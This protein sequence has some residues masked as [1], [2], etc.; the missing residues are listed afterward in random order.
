[1][2]NVSIISMGNITENKIPA[3]IGLPKRVSFPET[4][5]IREGPR[6][7][8][9]SP[10][11]ASIPNT[12]VEPFMLSDA[13]ESVPGHIIPT[14]KPHKPHP[15]S[16]ITGDGES[17]AIRYE[18]AHNTEHIIIHVFNGSLSAYI[19]YSTLEIPIISANIHGPRISPIAFETFSPDS[20][21]Y[22][23]H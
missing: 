21:K 2:S 8:P 9:I 20:A 10:V 19:P 17:E 4:T 13:R 7:H 5:D 16:A 11:S 18:M 23:A 15:S 3:L 14:E 1:M 12:A 6:V 22:D